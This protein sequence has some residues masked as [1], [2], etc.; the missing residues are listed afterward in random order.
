MGVRAAK[1]GV[2]RL[3]AALERHAHPVAAFLLPEVV[4]VDD[5]RNRGGEIRECA[6]LL[7]RHRNQL[8]HALGAE[9]GIDHQHLDEM[10][11]VDDRRQLVRIERQILEKVLVVDHRIRIDDADRVAVR[12]RILA[13]ARADIA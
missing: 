9:I 4:H 5:A 13:G 1:N 10:K 11:Q 6:R 12:L 2:G 7:L 8:I 3:P